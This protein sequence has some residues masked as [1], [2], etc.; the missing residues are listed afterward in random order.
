MGDISNT[1]LFEDALFERHSGVAW[2]PQQVTTL[3]L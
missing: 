2:W 1:Y 3:D